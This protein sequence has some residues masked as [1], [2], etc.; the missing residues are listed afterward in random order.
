MNIRDIK[1]L[2]GPNYWSNKRHKLIS[3]EL[4]LQEMETRPSN[5]IEGFNQRLKMLIPTL[6]EHHCSEGHDGGFFERLD[7]GTWMGHIIEHVALEIQTLAG[8]DCGFGRTR[9]TGEEGVYNVVFSYTEEKAGIYAANAGFRIIET[10]INED[11][12]DLEKDI[13]VLRE[14]RESEKLGPSTSSIVCEAEKRGI[15]WIRLNNSSLVQLGYGVNQKRIMATITSQ[16]SGIGVELAGDKEDTKYLL[17]K[18]AIPVPK[19]SVVL[20]KE[21]L[22]IELEDIGYPCVIKPVDGNHGRGATTNI[23]DL[24]SALI[25]FDL[26]KK[27]GERVVL[28]RF[29]S[30]F[31]FRLLVVNS[32]LVAAAKRTPAH[33]IGDGTATIQKLIDTVN[34]DPRR[35]FGHENMLTEITVDAMTD[36]ILK[37]NGYTLETVLPK[38]AVF[39][40]K[41]TA[42]LST[43]G[44]AEDVTDSVH[45][46][47]VFMAE[48][49]A[50]IIGLD[51]CGIDIMAHDLK[52][53][54]NENGGAVI[55]V[56]A[57]PGFRMHLAPTIGTARNV[58]DAVVDMLYP[59]GSSSRIP[60]VAITGTNGKTT[61]TRLIAHIMKGA[62]FKVGYTTSDGIYI[63]NRLLQ[64]G[65]CTGPKSAKFVLAD[66]T[67]DFAVLETARGG[68][69]REGLGFSFCDIGIV[70]NVTPDHLGLKGIQTM[71]QLA[72]VKSVVVENVCEEGYSILN[73]DDDL[74]MGMI[75]NIK[76]KIALFSLDENNARIQTHCSKGGIAAIYENGSVTINKGGWKIKVERAVNI[77]V[78]FSGKADFMIKNVLAATLAA[79][80]R[81]V[82]L[83]D[84]QIGLQTF[85]PSVALTPGRMNVFQFKNFKVLLD[86]AHNPSGMQALGQF[87]SQMEEYPK[88]GIISGTGDRRDEDIVELGEISASVFDEIIIRQDPELRGR[89]QEEIAALLTK[90]I[91]SQN[92][93]KMVTVASDERHA[94]LDS[95]KN[96]L[97][98]S[99]ITVLSDDI[100]NSIKLIESLMQKE[101][102]EI[103]QE[104]F[105]E[106]KT[107]D[108]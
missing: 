31:D 20:T 43:G 34:L 24:N 67:V 66:P 88:I 26:A 80:L 84:I 70:T 28:E 3:M 83:V 95:I 22:K 75:E 82:S 55:E 93:E 52:K 6:F 106:F 96:A 5:V 60:I 8:M 38:D 104:R 49:I 27:H 14:I 21:E 76:S 85:V 17:D 91:R 50:R 63:Q 35:G 36:W 32:Q 4:D 54:I 58:A 40:L 99:L 69:L 25:A 101:L 87:L 74:V 10:I 1:I 98:G 100:E 97:Q 65:D 78:T 90:G 48:R 71:E 102:A 39:A 42:N 107:A 62:G 19:G 77:P 59:V 44:T 11:Y 81:N 94:I 73:A 41:S 72:R 7:E 53:P 92:I 57:A 105:S 37:S 16:T 89:T 108:K 13:R 103:P 64:K 18:A 15:P 56:N 79:F 12:L 46:Y 61:T 45:P 9:G 68:I 33:I 86:Y 47:N 23:L 2:R 29:I 30:G 51:I